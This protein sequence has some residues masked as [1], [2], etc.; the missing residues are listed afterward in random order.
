MRWHEPLVAISIKSSPLVSAPLSALST[1]TS[2]HY[3]FVPVAVPE[4]LSQR[5]DNSSLR[6]LL[7]AGDCAFNS[8][9]LKDD[10]L[11]REYTSR[12][13]LSLK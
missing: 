3:R 10:S 8:M 7:V 5:K 2:R 13:R 11:R 4:Q 12:V 9:P 6:R 1:F